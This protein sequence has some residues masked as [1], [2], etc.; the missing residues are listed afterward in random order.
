LKKVKA[1]TQF[2]SFLII[3]NLAVARSTNENYPMKS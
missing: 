3:S 1:A 2:Y